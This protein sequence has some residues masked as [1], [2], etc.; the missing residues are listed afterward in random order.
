MNDCSFVLVKALVSF[1]YLASKNCL[2]LSQRIFTIMWE[3]FIYLDVVHNTNHKPFEWYWYA[4]FRINTHNMDGYLNISHIQIVI[5][6]ITYNF[7]FC[8]KNIICT[9]PCY[10]FVLKLSTLS[11]HFRT[12]PHRHTNFENIW[13]LLD[14][15]V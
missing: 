5:G 12:R 7:R 9:D 1:T 11:F 4:Q 13:N 10:S 8:F 2:Y 6:N 3:L 15:S 14:I